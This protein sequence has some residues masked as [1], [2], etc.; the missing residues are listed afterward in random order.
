M[1][2]LFSVLLLPLMMA[3]F[4]LTAGTA[5]GEPAPPP[6]PSNEEV[7]RRTELPWRDMGD[8]AAR[9]K[10]IS[11]ES[12]LPTLA[13]PPEQ[14]VG[15]QTVF[16]VSDEAANRYYT[17]RA[18]L[19]AITPH[20]YSYVANDVKVN[21]GKLRESAQYFEDRIYSVNRRYFGREPWIGLDGDPRVTLLH[22]KIPGV[23]GYFTSVDSYPR[24][25]QPYSNERKI[26]YLNVAVIAPGTD[27]YH[28]VVA[29]EFEHMVHWN[30]SRTEQTWV[31]EGAAE[32]ATEA[33][34][35]LAGSAD[36]F[37]AKPDTQ[38]TGW[39][40]SKGDVAPHYG[41][42]YLFLSYFLERFGGYQAAATL[43]TSETRGP[44]T[45]DRFLAL[46]GHRLTMEDVFKDWVVANY[47]D[48]SGTRDPRYRY[49]K[50]AV[51]VPA[52]DRISATTTGWRD[53]TVNQFAADYLELSGRWSGATVRFQGERTAR[54]IPPPAHS[55][56][57]FWWSNRGDMVDT[58]LTRLVDLSELSKATLSFW[59]WYDLEDDYDYAYVMV[60]R[61]GGLT[62]SV[63]KSTD[64]TES[65][66]NGNSLGPAFTGRSGNGDTPRWTQQKVDLSPYAG[67]LV[68]VRFELVTDDAYNAPGFAVDDLEIP[69][70]D[71]KTDFEADSGGWFADGFV[72]TDG[73]L[74]Q[75][76]SLQLIRFGR[77]ITV[78]Q[79]P[80]ATSGE[81]T[82]VLRNLDGGLEKAVLVVSAVTRDTSEPARYRYSVDISP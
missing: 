45:F 72:R 43:L 8:L 42:A 25:I 6:A 37:E 23:A 52:T 13:F 7:L 12:V 29:H 21:L 65:N 14:R 34:G 54:V 70:L 67:D 18:T 35:L 17:V 20:A 16:W 46:Q 15:D 19:Q 75:R 58:K 28:G 61:D 9:V 77:E 36:S 48:E 30:T 78:E 38:L 47:L 49:E 27:E 60:S 50:Q 39:A 11:R 33:A 82:V 32:V 69:E 40:G 66:P 64:S 80:V 79:L 22:A 74:E 76:F 41:A 71:Y 53:R 10:G 1:A 57:L 26:L 5:L 59:S 73:Q 3:L 31:K 44:D 51:R 55:G 4:G 68:L 56:R 2:R 81:A 63:L 62:W 24:S